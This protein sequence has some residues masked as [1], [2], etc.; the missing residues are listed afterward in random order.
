[1]FDVAIIQTEKAHGE[2]IKPPGSCQPRRLA[3]A[4]G[5]GALLGV[6]GFAGGPVIGI[7]AVAFTA[8]GGAMLGLLN[9]AYDLQD[10]RA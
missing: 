7:P 5:V 9:C 4:A 8:T 2:S 1:M 10:A 3:A 6:G